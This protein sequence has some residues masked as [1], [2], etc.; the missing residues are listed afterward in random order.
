MPI[1]VLSSFSVSLELFDVADDADGMSLAGAARKRITLLP[2]RPSR[3]K[4]IS[5]PKARSDVWARRR[6]PAACGANRGGVPIGV[7][8]RCRSAWL[9]CWSF[10]CSWGQTSELNDRHLDADADAV[11]IVPDWARQS[12][13]GDAD[14]AGGNDHRGC[15][16]SSLTHGVVPQPHLDLGATITKIV[17]DLVESSVQMHPASAD[18]C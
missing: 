14:Q 15:R 6:R 3:W 7:G 11:A 17:C 16:N 8:S 5:I 13:L 9:T 18:V 12:S 2:A 1:S 10:W 4:T